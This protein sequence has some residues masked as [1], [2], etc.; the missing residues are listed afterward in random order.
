MTVRGLALEIAQV[1]SSI[2]SSLML[3]VT[4]MV[5]AHVL[6]RSLWGKTLISLSAIPLSIAKNGLR[7][8]ILAV[9]GVYVDRGFLNGRLHRQ[10]GIVF[11]LLS[12]ASLFVLIWLVGWAER[13]AA[14]PALK[15]AAS[16]SVSAGKQALIGS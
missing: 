9:L 14:Q 16:L 4:T 1:C 7:I 15:E 8:F 10:G 3:V 5:M 12:L 11:F 6:L 2:R 13:K